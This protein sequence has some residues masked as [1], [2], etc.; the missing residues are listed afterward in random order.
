MGAGALRV[1]ELSAISSDLASKRKP[2]Q[3]N[4]KEAHRVP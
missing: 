4:N 2:N 1:Q 3:N